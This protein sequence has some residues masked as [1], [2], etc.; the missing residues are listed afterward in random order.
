MPP[1]YKPPKLISSSPLIIDLMSATSLQAHNPEHSPARPL[2]ILR[3]LP[4]VADL[5]EVCFSSTLDDE[6]QSYLQN[7]RRASRDDNFLRWAGN[8]IDSA[9][10]PMTGYVW[11]ENGR[12]IGNASL[13]YNHYK[14]KKL[15]LIAN[16]ATHP[17]YRRRGIGRI[18]TERALNHARQKNVST[19]WLQV[20]EDNPTA[21]KIYS[22]LG[23]VER[24][25]RTTYT[26]K[27]GTPLAGPENGL[28]IS[29][30]NPRD[31]P[32]QQK[33]LEH[34]Y[35]EELGWYKHFE[36]NLFTPGLWNWLYRF[37]VEL[38]MRQ[39]AAYKNGELLA[40]LGWISS[41]NLPDT[42]YAAAKP[43]GDA[44]ALRS[45]LEAARRN[46]GAQRKLSVD[47]PA[48]EMSEAFQSAGFSVY[49]TLL[50]MSATS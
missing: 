47:Y 10:L 13:M 34:S 31:W 14:G 21:I 45:A 20:R 4:Q 15:A 3:D 9:S 42:L 22:D 37:F 44:A 36:W 38:D 46:L 28:P 50:W 1:N 18:L 8:V 39:W 2:N 43:D 29:K 6:S 35:P 24:A 40:T 27:L 16:V 5:I 30:V 32:L 19:I 41:W 25:R 49:R 26:V 48:G 23:F 33:W 11:E 12:I 7:M 17:D